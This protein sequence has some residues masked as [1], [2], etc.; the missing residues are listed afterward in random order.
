MS[1]INSN[2]SAAA[3]KKRHAGK[4]LELDMTT[5][6]IAKNLITFAFPLLV[7]NLFQQLYN[8]VDTWVI[9][10]TGIAG[11]YAAVGSIGPIINILIGFFSG[12][13]SGVGVVISRHFGARDEDGVRRAVHTSMVMTL[14]LAVAFTVLG[15]IL[16]PEMLDLMLDNEREGFDEMYGAGETY[17]RIYFAGVAGLMLY[18]MGAGI[19]RAVGD[20]Q[21]PL[22]FLI[23]CAVTNTVLD[24]VFVFCFHMGVAGVALATVISQCLSA[25]LTLIVLFRTDSC[26]R[27]RLKWLRVDTAMLKR[28]INIGIPSA[29]QMALTAF[30]NVFVQSYI[31]GTEGNMTVNTGGWTTYSKVDQF[32]FLPMQSLALATT[33]FVGQNLGVGNVERAKTGARMAY[34]MSTACSIVIMVPTMIFAAPISGIFNSDPEIVATSTRLLHVITPFYLFC[35]VNQVFSA[36]LRGAGNSRVPMLIMLTSFI[37]VRQVYLFIMSRYISNELIP[38]GISYPVGW[39]T[40]CVLTLIYYLHFDFAKV[41]TVSEENSE[42][43]AVEG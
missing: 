30:A 27:L 34:F 8:M 11:D 23:V 29:I 31:A 32:I 26:V 2:S 40:C 13:A 21:R 20:S 18:N 10:Q 41:K 24:V 6:S 7:G 14:V 36:A 28:I 25:V 22:Y 42:P 1:N 19:L 16:A 39:F 12:L 43:E 37:G 15:V 4:K 33:T 3:V 17:L 38:I 35:S 9:G 5:G